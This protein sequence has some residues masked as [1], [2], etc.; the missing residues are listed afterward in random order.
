MNL[1]F[2]RVFAFLGWTA[3]RRSPKEN[4]FESLRKLAIILSKGAIALKGEIGENGGV[5]F[6]AERTNGER[7]RFFLNPGADLAF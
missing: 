1:R 2:L 4:G 5:R 3:E 6:P 7:V